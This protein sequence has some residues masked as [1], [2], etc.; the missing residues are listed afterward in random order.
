MRFM[1]MYTYIHHAHCMQTHKLIH[2]NHE[3]VF[4]KVTWYQNIHVLKSKKIQ[5][6]EWRSDDA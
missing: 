2:L 3:Q 5:K 6:I 1:L 4:K